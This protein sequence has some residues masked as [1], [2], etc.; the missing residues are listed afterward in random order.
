MDCYKSL[1]DRFRTCSDRY[2]GNIVVVQ[3]LTQE[4]Q[5]GM[6]CWYVNVKN[7]NEQKIYNLR[8]PDIKKKGTKLQ[9]QN[10]YILKLQ[11]NYILKLII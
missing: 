3:S 8:L 4:E 10:N 2:I 1:S 7:L 6:T 5:M 11:N 9:L